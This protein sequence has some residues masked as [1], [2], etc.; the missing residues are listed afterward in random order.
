[1][2]HLVKL[3]PLDKNTEEFIKLLKC[4]DLVRNFDLFEDYSV[5]NFYQDVCKTLK[6]DSALNEKP[7]LKNVNKN[8]FK[9]NY[10]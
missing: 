1:M 6:N 4:Q 10:V 5:S 8:L 9:N 2:S 7:L 3:N